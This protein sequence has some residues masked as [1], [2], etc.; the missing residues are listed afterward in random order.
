MTP[1]LNTIT[2]DAEKLC[3]P[4]SDIIRYSGCRQ[5]KDEKLCAMCKEASD[6]LCALITPRAVFAEVCVKFAEDV[7]DFGFCKYESRSLRKFLGG[8]CTAYIFAATLGVGAD[9]LIARYSPILPSRAVVTDG[10]ATAS[11]ECFCDY[12]C[13]EIFKTDEQARFSPGYGDLPLKMQ[14][15]ILALLDANLKIGLSMTDSYLLTPTKSV[16]AIVKKPDSL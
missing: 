5:S 16:T 10:C 14:K 12:I 7:A 9:R 15:D 8:D 4:T 13:R 1:Y 11:I 3:I 2:L 6:E